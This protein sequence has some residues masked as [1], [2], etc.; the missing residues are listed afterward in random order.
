MV[1]LPVD[2]RITGITARSLHPGRFALTYPRPHLSL[3][4]NGAPPET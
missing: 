1:K 3:K 2:G 4:P